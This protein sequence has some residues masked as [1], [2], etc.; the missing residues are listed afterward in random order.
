MSDQTIKQASVPPRWFIRSFWSMHRALYRVTGG[1]GGVDDIG[2]I[3]GAEGGT[4]DIIGIPWT[5][6]ALKYFGHID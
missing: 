1:T 6:M 3:R 4:D 5:I 2:G